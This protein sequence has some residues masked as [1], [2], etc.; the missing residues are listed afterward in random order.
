MTGP[1]VAALDLSLSST[2]LA[3]PDGTLATITSRY[4]G[5]ER[6]MDVRN[7]IAALL[8]HHEHGYPDLVVIE[9]YS[10]ASRNSHAHALGELGGVIRVFLYAVGVPVVEVSPAALKKAATGRG[11][12]AKD[13]V[14]VAAVQRLNITPANSDEADAAWLRAMALDH[15]GAPVAAVP[16]T[17]RTALDKIAWPT[18]EGAH[19]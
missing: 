8:N 11:N 12:A 16:K 5:V 19:A 3:L 14:L 18:L 13:Q 6:L 15:Y 4:R 9:G 10:F 7:Q 17:H 2:G 1:R